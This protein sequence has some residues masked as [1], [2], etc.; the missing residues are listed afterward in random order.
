MKNTLN[1]V[2]ELAFADELQKIAAGY[3]FE[4]AVSAGK[5]MP[6]AAAPAVTSKQQVYAS[7][8]KAMGSN[9][10]RST[11]PAA[12]PITSKQQVYA[13]VNKALGS[14]APQA[15][16]SNRLPLKA[17]GGNPAP[18]AP[19][20]QP[21]QFAAAAAR[22]KPAAGFNN[23]NAAVTARNAATRGT[24]QWASAQNV[25]NTAYGR[26]PVNRQASFSTMQNAGAAMP[27]GRVAGQGGTLVQSS[28]TMAQMFPEKFGKP[29]ATQVAAAPV[30]KNTNQPAPI[31]Q[32]KPSVQDA[33]AMG[34]RAAA[35]NPNDHFARMDAIKRSGV[36]SFVS[37]R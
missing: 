32:P 24:P 27:G 3:N 30:A 26:G 11:A 37:V 23:L 7:V 9:A 28:Q 35:A 12:A 16:A 34:D 4:G 8:N 14:N 15:T 31:A 10:P 6:A 22:F 25:I 5:S 29:A 19:V 2:A 17:I 13:N 33:I 18:A 1:K 21:N 20:A 36:G